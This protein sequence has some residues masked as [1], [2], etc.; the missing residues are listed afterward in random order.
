[1][2]ATVN[3]LVLYSI[4]FHTDVCKKS[5]IQNDLP[6]ITQVKLTTYLFN[7]IAANISERNYDYALKTIYTIQ[8]DCFDIVYKCILL[9]F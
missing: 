4:S 3:S 9:M 5:E 2:N 1:M 8:M 6:I 7:K